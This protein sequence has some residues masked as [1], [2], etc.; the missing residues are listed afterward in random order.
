MKTYEIEFVRT[1]AYSLSEFAE[2]QAHV[3]AET[4]DKAR[5]RFISE[6]AV[7]GCSFNPPN[8]HW[9]KLERILSVEEYKGN[10]LF[11]TEDQDF[12]YFNALEENTFGGLIS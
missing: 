10:S 1:P 4:K 6:M 11:D 5:E 2:E 3:K 12:S 9:D 8:E 7:I